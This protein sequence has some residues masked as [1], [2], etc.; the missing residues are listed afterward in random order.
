[1][2]AAE[3]WSSEVWPLDSPLRVTMLGIRGFPH[4]QGG[5][6][7]HAQHLSARLVELGCEVEVIVRSP[8]VPRNADRTWHNVRIVRVWSP[9]I[10]GVEVFLHTLL[11]V[12]RAAWTRPDV[13]HIHAIGPALF[14]PLARAFGLRVVVTHHVLNYENEKWGCVARS[15]L[16]LGE[17]AGMLFANGRIAV[18]EALAHRMERAYRKPVCVIPNGIG[19]PQTVQST[20]TLTAFGLISKRYV[21]TVARIDEQKRQ[22][23]LIEAFA[24]A[25]QAPWKLAIVGGADY[26]SEYA[27]AVAQAAQKT[28]GVVMLGHQTGEALA[29]LYKHAGVFVLP[30]SHEGQPIAVLEA[31][32]YGCPVVLSDIPAHREIGTSSAQFVRVG[33]VAALADRLDAIFRTGRAPRL[34]ADERERLM[35]RHDWR[36]IARL[37]LGVYHA[38]LSG[39]RRSARC[40]PLRT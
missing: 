11:G 5:A 33:D 24:Q 18:S 7:N 28:P 32:S 31:M 35:Q 23:D 34:D 16:R 20:S 4:V 25:R 27:R 10:K 36:Q 38:A 2:T 21:L 8:Y 3:R 30:S 1:M 17:R 22:L 26:S 37:T 6:E 15:I 13:L 29:Q 14:T 9:R 12:L 39:R 40:D 19:D